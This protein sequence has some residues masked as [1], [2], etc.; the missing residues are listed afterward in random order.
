[1]GKKFSKETSLMTPEIK[2]VLIK[3]EN[4]GFQNS[5]MIMLGKSIFCFAKKDNVNQIQKI[6]NQELPL[7]FIF[8][9]EIDFKGARLLQG[10]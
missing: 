9:T 7:W 2:K 8:K 5:S 10:D 1:M 3:L 4:V 6:L